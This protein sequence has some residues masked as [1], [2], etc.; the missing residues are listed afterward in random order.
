MEDFWAYF[1]TIVSADG[2]I[3]KDK[4]NSIF[5]KFAVNQ[6]EDSG[7]LY[8]IVDQ[9]SLMIIMTLG[10]DVDTNRKEKL[11]SRLLSRFIAILP[12]FSNFLFRLFDADG[13]GGISKSEFIAVMCLQHPQHILPALFRALDTNCNGV[14]ESIE[15]ASFASDVINALVSL[16]EALLDEIEPILE[17]PVKKFFFEFFST[18][19]DGAASINIQSCVDACSLEVFA[20]ANRDNAEGLSERT[21][22]ASMAVDYLLIPI[23]SLQAP[24]TVVQTW[25]D[26]LEKF[27]ESADATSCS[28]PKADAVRLANQSFS[29]LVD[30]YCDSSRALR[31]L[32]NVLAKLIPGFELEE[33][34]LDDVLTSATGAARA[35]LKGGGLKR[36]LEAIF[37]FLDINN[38]GQISVDELLGLS[39]AASRL[40][41]AQTYYSCVP[42]E[43]KEEFELAFPA[44]LKCLMCVFDGNNDG[45]LDQQDIEKVFDKLCEIFRA[46]CLLLSSGIK[47]TSMASIQSLCNLALLIKSKIIGG[48]ADNVNLDEI[49]CFLGQLDT[50]QD[51]EGSELGG[52]TTD[53]RVIM[54]GPDNAGKTTLLY[55]FLLGDTVCTVPTI[56]FNVETVEYCER[57][58]ILWDI[59]GSPGVRPLMVH[60]FENSNMILFV[61]DASDSSRITEAREMLAQALADPQLLGLPLVVCANKI[62]L[63]GLADDEA[64]LHSKLGELSQELG[65]PSISDRVHKILACSASNGSGCDEILPLLDELCRSVE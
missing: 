18:F 50:Q 51:T 65:L 38:D 41:D 4:F 36:F 53:K 14:L 13:S 27:K 63:L 2:T 11:K 46:C 1:D 25:K 57:S 44:F 16:L 59:G 43:G 49:S 33:Y 60:Y 54:I 31:L 62:D 28:L 47:H 45:S 61:V 30:K 34:E 26:F 58:Y 42:D 39:A 3:D 17:V 48:E 20:S 6:L 9:L 24:G 55:R 56:G 10:T 5:E 7:L 8:S 37:N 35:F 23:A 19:T 29:V 21:K 64:K 12:V 32:M 15:L 40:L 22:M 52:S